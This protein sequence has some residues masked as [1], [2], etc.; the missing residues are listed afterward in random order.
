MRI[1]FTITND[2]TYDQRMIRIATSLSKAGYQPILVGRKLRNSNELI[3]Q[4]FVHHRIKCFFNK[5]KMFYAEFN[6]RLFFY[7]L[8]KKMDAVCAIDLDTILPCYFVSRLRNIKRIYDAHELFCEMKEI[9][10]R[11][12][13]YKVWKQ[14]EKFTV[15]KFK[16]GYTISSA[17]AVEFEKMYGVNYEIIRNISLNKNISI[18]DKKEKYIIYQGAVNEG[19][20]FESIIPAMKHVDARLIICGDGN[21]MKQAKQLVIKNNLQEKIIFKGSVPPA[22][23]ESYTLY[24]WAGIN[25][26]DNKGLNSYFSLANRFF[27]YIHAGLPQLCADIPSYSEINSR[28][29][30]AILI[31][32]I[33]PGDIARHLNILL[34]DEQLYH[35]LQQNCL[36]AKE[37]YNWQLEE[38]KLITFYK[39]LFG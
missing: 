25:L 24:A 17:I 5:G 22:Q 36:K 6:I 15:P 11:P 23:L 34:K 2:L 39:A 1:Y 3:S 10:S 12:A 29:E 28:F 20:S 16:N 32:G 38:I 30:V 21:F 4:P 9:V 19:R 13:I 7:L 8:I 14:I 37:V 31:P 27:D 33:S 35:R 18:P 26:V